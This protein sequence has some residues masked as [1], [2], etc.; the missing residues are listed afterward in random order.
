[1]KHF[2]PYLLFDGNCAE[3]MEFYK[4]I[5]GGELMITKT[6]DSTIKDK[7]PQ[8]KQDLVVFAKLTS[9][10]LE[11]IAGDWMQPTQ[12]PQQGNMVCLHIECEN[13]EEMKKYF[14]KLAV[15][16]DPTLTEPIAEQFFGMYGSLIDKYG[17]RWMFR[18]RN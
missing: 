1:M 3:A 6:S 16:A 2:T 4:T 18:K 9:G 12:K 15:D 13:E 11:F 7:M 8:E 17:I 14:D 5:F 10:V